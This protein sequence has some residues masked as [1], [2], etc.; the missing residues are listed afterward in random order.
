MR[1]VISDGWRP[2]EILDSAVFHQRVLTFILAESWITRQWALV[3]AVRSVLMKACL[4]CA[5]GPQKWSLQDF[6]GESLL[7]TQLF[8]SGNMQSSLVSPGLSS[9][10]HICFQVFSCYTPPR[11]LGVSQKHAQFRGQSRTSGKFICRCQGSPM[12]H[13]PFWGIPQFL[14]TL[15]L[16]ALISDASA[17]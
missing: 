9:C 16:Q 1:L 17:Q 12:T 5:L 6:H 3:A 13:V 14:M 11:P 4:D 7:C 15:E 2:E 10:P 8:P